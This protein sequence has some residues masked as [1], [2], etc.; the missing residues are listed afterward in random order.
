[1]IHIGEID[2]LSI[3]LVKVS[4]ITEKDHGCEGQDL[5]PYYD[6]LK[7]RISKKGILVPVVL[8]VVN[9][10]YGVCDGWHRWKIAKE[11]SIETIPAV[12]FDTIKDC[13]PTENLRW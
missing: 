13:Y 4:E 9:T 12:I 3:Y 2:S 10:G 11:L 1:M 5:E 6:R 7:Q 8:Y